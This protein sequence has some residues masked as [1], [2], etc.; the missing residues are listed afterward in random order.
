MAHSTGSSSSTSNSTPKGNA[1]DEE[2]Q[3]ENRKEADTTRTLHL[4][5]QRDFVVDGAEAEW[6]VGE[7]KVVIY[8]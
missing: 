8:V 1:A 3:R 4:K 2:A 7:E 5:R 6:E